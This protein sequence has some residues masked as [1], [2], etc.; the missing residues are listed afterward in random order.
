[1]AKLNGESA[2]HSARLA[3]LEGEQS[4]LGESIRELERLRDDLS[5]DTASR[6][7]MIGQFE[8]QNDYL[9]RRIREEE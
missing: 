7:A 1:M 5:G 4:A 3:G 6:A 2:Q 9:A 8:Q